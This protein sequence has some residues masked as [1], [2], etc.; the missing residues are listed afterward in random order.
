M[1]NNSQGKRGHNAREGSPVQDEL[2]A[3]LAPTAMDTPPAEEPLDDVQYVGSLL[4]EM[5]ITS[6]GVLVMAGLLSL[7]MTIT[8][9]FTTFLVIFVTFLVGLA[10]FMQLS[11]GWR[12][13]LP[14]GWA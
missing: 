14:Q 12:R 11:G 9:F 2:E 7:E 13:C 1:W 5:T 6:R 3:V 8:S 10:S 4:S